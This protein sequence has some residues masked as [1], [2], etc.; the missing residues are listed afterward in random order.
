MRKEEEEA[1]VPSEIVAFAH[2]YAAWVAYQADH[3][4]LLK[5]ITGINPED[6]VYAEDDMVS[7]RKELCTELKSELGALL[8]VASSY[9]TENDSSTTRGMGLRWEARAIFLAR[10]ADATTSF[11][12]KHD[13]ILLPASTRLG[14]VRPLSANVIVC[15]AC[16]RPLRLKGPRS[17]S[18]KTPS[19][20]EGRSSKDEPKKMEARHARPHTTSTTPENPVGELLQCGGEHHIPRSSSVGG[21]VFKMSR[22]A[23]SLKGNPEPNDSTEELVLM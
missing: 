23:E 1:D 11:L 16:D 14:R 17:H 7:R 2:D 19:D 9:P 4:S 22:L 21:T 10:V 15:L 20:G 8:E 18:T 6:Q 3:E 12:G 5:L 13:Q